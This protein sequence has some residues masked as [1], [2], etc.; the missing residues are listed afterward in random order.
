MRMT[1]RILAL[2]TAVAMIAAVTGCQSYAQG[3]GLGA[4]L[5]GAAGAIIGHQSGH[6]LEGAAIG[7][8]VGGLTGLVAHDIK[9]QKQ[10][11][12]EETAAEYNYQP[13][14]GEMLTFERAEVLPPVVAPGEMFTVTMQYAI[15]GTG[16]GVT[17]TET[18]TLMRDQEVIADLS[19]KGEVRTDGT[20]VSEQ[21]FRLPT[22]LSPGIYT[23]VA[24]AQTAQSAISGRAN[25]TVE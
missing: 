10:K 17:V 19:S 9:A 6:A 11:K 25:F 12:R 3:G 7:A 15:L 1:I 5:G 8:V 23:V 22:N 16:N 24:R 14:Q 21:D 2:V 4:A 13:Q 18:R 20:W